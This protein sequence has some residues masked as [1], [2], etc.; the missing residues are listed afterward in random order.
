MRTLLQDLRYGLRMLAKNPGFTAVAVLTLA[1]GIGANTAMF[2]VVNAALLRPLPYP[3]PGRIVQIAL[4]Y[5]GQTENTNFSSKQFDFWKSH[6]G[7]FQDLAATTGQG[8]NLGG[9]SRPERVMRA[10][11]VSPRSRS[12]TMNGTPFGS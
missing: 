2:S 10:R 6:G 4:L 12:I 7:P 9:V 11:S 3:D 5:R 8:F 1:L